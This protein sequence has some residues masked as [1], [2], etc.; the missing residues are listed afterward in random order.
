MDYTWTWIAGFVI[1]VVSSL[2]CARLATN[3]GRSATGFAILG[4][5]LPLIG[6]IVAAL[7]P[8]KTT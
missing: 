7:I 2:L 6:L 4:F 5:F 1:A 8:A 3:K